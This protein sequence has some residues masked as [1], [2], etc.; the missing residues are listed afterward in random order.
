MS[1]FQKGKKWKGKKIPGHAEEQKNIIE[2][3]RKTWQQVKLQKVK[4]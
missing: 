1:Y 4:N 2:R 3:S